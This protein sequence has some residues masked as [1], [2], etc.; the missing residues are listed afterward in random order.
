MLGVTTM[1]NFFT[2]SNKFRSKLPVVS[3][4]TAMNMWDG[5]CMFFIYAS[6]LEFMV[7]NYLARW[8]QDPEN[9]KKKR[10]NAILDS[11]RIVSTTLDLK[12]PEKAGT[13]GGQLHSFGGNL[14][15]KLKEVKTKLPTEITS[16]V[17]AIM[18]EKPLEK[19]G[20]ETP[21]VV[22]P[23]PATV[24]EEESQGPGGYTLTSVK[25]IDTYS[26]RIFPCSYICFVLY[27]FIRYHLIEGDLSIEFWW[28]HPFESSFPC[29]P[30][31]NGYFI[32][33]KSIS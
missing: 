25:K 2:T 28:G 1:L 19:N 12:H 4:L 7:V 17:P 11:L 9:N 23:P 24:A 10:E 32:F 18:Q 5:I 31:I 16:K 13:L 3:N 27:F 22:V 29:F 30:V 20:E 33:N 21:A 15:T 6:F 8:V 14:E 26:R